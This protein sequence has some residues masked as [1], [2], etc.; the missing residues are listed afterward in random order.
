MKITNFKN[1][2][3]AMATLFLIA[4]CTNSQNSKQENQASSVE[5]STTNATPKSSDTTNKN[6]PLANPANNEINTVVTQYLALKNALV[7]DDA[8]AAASAGKSIVDA[9]AK[10]DM[11]AL[12]PQQM[13]AYIDVADDLKENAEHIGDNAGKIDH[14]REHFAL[15][16]KDINDIVQV[17]GTNGQKLYQDFCPMFNDGKGAIW[18]SENKDI[19]NPFY[20]SQMLTCGKVKKEY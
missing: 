13:K 4:S 12:N 18:L 3:V 9:M 20:G 5:K 17:F 10:I 14:Q 11:K 16:S 6:Q 15:L 8:K 1:A 2:F 7:K 19:K